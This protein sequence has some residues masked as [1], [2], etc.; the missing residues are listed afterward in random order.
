M[1][2]GRW[3]SFHAWYQSEK[4]G[5]RVQMWGRTGDPIFENIVANHGNDY[6]KL[7]DSVEYTDCLV[8]AL[9]FSTHQFISISAQAMPEFSR[10]IAKA[11]DRIKRTERGGF[12]MSQSRHVFVLC[13]KGIHAKNGRR[14]SE[15]LR[16]ELD[17]AGHTNTQICVWV[18]PGHTEELTRGKPNA[19]IM[20]GEDAKTT[21]DVIKMCSSDLIRLYQG[22]DMLGVEIGGAAKNV[23]GIAAGMLD[24]AGMTSLKGA[25]MARGF[26]E[27][28]NLIVAMGGKRLTAYG[29]S[30]LGDSEA[31]IF[32]AISSNRNYGENFITGKESTRL[33]EGVDTSIAM[34]KLGKQHKV[35]MPITNLVYRALHKGD[36]PMELFAKMFQG[37]TNRREFGE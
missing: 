2:C 20:D 36:N 22:D 23:I 29:L 16:T 35:D 15:I 10:N 24:G 1:G 25:L 31:T 8:D 37:R 21:A 27:V 5:N 12:K 30:L 34:H 11:L 18:G 17:K 13:M 3:A 6:V 32:S 26:Y 9:K 28:S 19:M 14:L 7:S 4:L 33:A